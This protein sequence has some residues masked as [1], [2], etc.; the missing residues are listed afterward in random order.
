MGAFVE[1]IGKSP[2][3]AWRVVAITYIA[4]GL[5]TF[6]AFLYRN[7]YVLKVGEEDGGTAFFFRST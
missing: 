2:K 3:S 6:A 4:V 5:L 1:S 7:F